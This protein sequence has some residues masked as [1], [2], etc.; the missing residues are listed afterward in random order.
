MA[1]RHHKKAEG[2]RVASREEP[3]DRDFSK[4]AEVEK[5]AEERKHGGRVKK[6]HEGKKH[7]HEKKHEGHMA[8]GHAAKRRMDRPGRKR[9]GRCGADM[10]PLS[11]AHN[12]TRESGVQ[13]TEAD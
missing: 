12:T 5:D 7:E 13:S 2:G 9:G 3:P 8:E 4:N 11:S 10:S 1:A 6:K